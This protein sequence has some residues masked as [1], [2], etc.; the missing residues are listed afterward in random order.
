MERLV[1]DTNAVAA[2]LV[3]EGF[4]RRVILVSGLSFFAPDFLR[5]ELEE[6]RDVFIAKSGLASEDYGRVMDTV[7][8]NIVQISAANYLPFKEKALGLTEDPDDWPFLALALS[9]SCPIW[10]N[11]KNMKRQGEVKVYSTGEFAS[12]LPPESA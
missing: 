2:A 9:L 3:K 11:D 7:L 5:D 4:S 1:V 6:H 8:A 12:L 10:S